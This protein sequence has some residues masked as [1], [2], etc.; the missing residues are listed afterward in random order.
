MADKD[1]PLLGTSAPV[2][3]NIMKIWT[4]FFYACSSLLITI[5]NKTVLTTYE[6]PSFNILAMGQLVATVVILFLGKQFSVIKFPDFNSRTVSEISPLP[7][8]YLGNMVFGLGGTKE[9]SLPMFTMLRRFAIL[10]TM[11][12]EF[13]V[14]NIR[15]KLSVKISVAL[16]VLGAMIAAG[17]DLGFNFQGYSFVLIND[18]LTA[19][20]SVYTKKKLNTQKEMGKYGLMF[21]CALLMLPV[22]FLLNFGMGEMQ[23]VYEYEYWTDTMFIIQ[24]VLSCTMGFVLN[25]S[26]MLCTQYN[27]AL[28]TTIMGCL[29]NI[30]VTYLGMFIGGDYRYSLTNF[31]GINLSIIG[32][33]L[34]TYV[35]FRPPPKS[36]PPD[37]VQVL[38][39]GK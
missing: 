26:V 32:S 33:L 39:H 19:A 34:Y 11:I 2:Y 30:L 15:P 38:T 14:L 25:Y 13:Y 23:R 24:F 16:M 3:S 9:L 1:Q 6:F 29:K 20:N 37:P 18:F 12:A 4:A 21:Y 17:N 35:T 7:F 31:V 8:I 36:V 5:V 27:S 28:T 10:M 22:S